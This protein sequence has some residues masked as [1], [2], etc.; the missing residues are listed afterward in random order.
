MIKIRQ[1]I[2]IEQVYSQAKKEKS[3]KIRARLLAIAAVLEG[4][5]RGHAAKIAGLTI[6]NIKTWII[7]FNADGF[8][9][10]K[11]KKRKGMK[12]RW[13]NEIEQCVKEKAFLGASLRSDSALQATNPATPIGLIGDSVPP[14]SIRSAS[15]RMMCC[16]A[17]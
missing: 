3:A 8:D 9:G 15:P 17:E 5:P 10:L 7:R 2:S 16:A 12:P 14:Q 6:D 13:T 4:K 11:G 1:D